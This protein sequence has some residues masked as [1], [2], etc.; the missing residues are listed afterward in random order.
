MIVEARAS[1]PCGADGRDARRSTLYLLN[2]FPTFSLKNFA[3]ISS[4]SLVS[5][6]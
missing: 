6:N 4:A 2:Y 3:I 1:R 5:G